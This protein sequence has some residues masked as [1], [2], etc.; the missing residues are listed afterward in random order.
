MEINGIRVGLY[1]HR[2]LCVCD[3][4]RCTPKAFRLVFGRRLHRMLIASDIFAFQPMMCARPRANQLRLTQQKKK[5][6]VSLWTCPN[7]QGRAARILVA[8]VAQP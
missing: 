5:R 4:R 1:S 8:N 2:R 7:E 6:T 3:E